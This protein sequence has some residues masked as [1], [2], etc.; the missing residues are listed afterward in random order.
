MSPLL[1]AIAASFGFALMVVVAFT[2]RGP[3]D[4]AGID[5]ALSNGGLLVDVRT[6]NEYGLGHLPGAINIPVQELADRLG[7]LPRNKP[8]VLYCAS[9]MRSL[10]A[11][12]L[13]KRSGF[14]QVLDLG[15]MGNAAQLSSLSQ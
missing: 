6:F 3:K 2:R 1:L 11:D 7:E 5:I 8:I 9:G 12:L 10:R 14:E 15:A 4:I 13:L